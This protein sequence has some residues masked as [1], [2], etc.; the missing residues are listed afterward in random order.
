MNGP[1]PSAPSCPLAVLHWLQS[2]AAF[3]AE[4][5]QHMAPL[6]AERPWRPWMPFL[7]AA[8]AAPALPISSGAAITA[9][10]AIIAGLLTA[11]LW[12]LRREIK[13]NDE[14]HRD[15]GRRIGKVEDAVNGNTTSLAR[16]EGLLEG[17]IRSAGLDP[18]ID[19][20]RRRS[21][22]TPTRR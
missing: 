2:D 9:L 10:L 15:L 12:F 16:V 8:G 14:A 22:E 13:N 20:V 3:L 18:L 4:A 7:L 1:D 5:L 21:A 6:G 11:L 19:E 17:M